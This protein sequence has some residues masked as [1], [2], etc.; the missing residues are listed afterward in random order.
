LALGEKKPMGRSRAVRRPAGTSRMA[1]MV[2]TTPEESLLG[3]GVARL[4][5]GEAGGRA[6]IEATKRNDPNITAAFE[7]YG[8]RGF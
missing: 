2:L 6:N 4:F 1:G 8:V 7:G 3:H 5:H